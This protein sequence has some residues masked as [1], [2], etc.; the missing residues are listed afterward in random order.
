MCLRNLNFILVNTRNSDTSTAIFLSR[1]H[2]VMM[3]CKEGLGEYSKTHKDAN[4]NRDNMYSSSW[5]RQGHT[6]PDPPDSP[7]PGTKL[8]CERRETPPV[9]APRTPA[10]SA[11]HGCARIS[12]W[13]LE[14]EPPTGAT[15]VGTRAA[16]TRKLGGRRIARQ[17]SAETLGVVRRP[18]KAPCPPGSRFGSSFLSIIFFPRTAISVIVGGRERGRERDDK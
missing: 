7:P 11:I 8:T 14:G 12:P 10:S 17:P 15:E 18:Q 4:T 6:P 3:Y 16:D 1:T 13:T 9:R 2:D 5:R